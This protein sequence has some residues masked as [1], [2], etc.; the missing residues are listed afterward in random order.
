[1]NIEKDELV[2]ILQEQFDLIEPLIGKMKDISK[3]VFLSDDVS[4][5]G[6]EIDKV[7]EKLADVFDSID[8]LIL[9]VED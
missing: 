6:Y 2:D 4:E 7:I 5:E 9:D 8:G 3:A 1:M